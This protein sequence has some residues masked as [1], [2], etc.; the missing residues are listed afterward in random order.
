[1]CRSNGRSIIIGIIIVSFCGILSRL[2]SCPPM[3]T[4]HILGLKGSIPPT[5]IMIL[6]WM[7]WYI[8]LGVCCGSVLG[9]RM[10]SKEVYKYKGSMFFVIMM[11]FNIIWYPMFFSA[12]AIFLAFWD[13]V[14]MLFFC[15]LTAFSYMK[16]YLF[17]GACMF[18]HCVWLLYCLI[19][20]GF[21][22]MKI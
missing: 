2:L 5:W 1:M 18:I 6:I 21:A 8:L 10:R 3:R 20:N 12:N 17:A 22:I 14:I 19:I 4:I 16:V 9:C 7:I 13:I 11:V 15:L